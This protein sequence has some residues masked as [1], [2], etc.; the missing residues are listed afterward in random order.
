MNTLQMGE[1]LVLLKLALPKYAPSDVNNALIKVWVDALK[2][3]EEPRLKAAFAHA[4]KSL[5]EWPSPAIIRRLSMG[6]VNNN[7]ELVADIVCRIESNISSWGYMQPVKAEKALGPQ[8]WEVV[9][10]MG[11]WTNIC[12][13]IEHNSELPSFR[14]RARDTAE[15]VITRVMSTGQN[16]V[17]H[18]PTGRS[19]RPAL[20]SEALKIQIIP[21]WPW[22][23]RELGFFLVFTRP[24]LCLRYM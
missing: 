23:Y 5:T 7:N 1:M 24:Y 12:R 6:V 2:D 3:I 4:K 15:A 19:E 10:M 18:L 13:S 16:K 14:K 21:L 22:L 9:N 20:V 11:G 17:P 8:A